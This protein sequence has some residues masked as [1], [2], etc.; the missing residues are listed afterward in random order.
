ME[1]NKDQKAVEAE[2]IKENTSST[3]NSNKVV[4]FIKAKKMIIGVLIIAIILIIVIVNLIVVS[5]KEAV[6]KFVKAF[7]D[8][9]LEKMVDSMD[10][11]GFYVFSGLDEDEYDDFWSEYKDFKDSSDYEDLMDNMNDTLDDKDA[12]ED[13]EDELKDLDY[14]MKIDKIKDVKKISSHLYRVKVKL[15]LSY[16]DEKDTQTVNCYV[17]KDGAKSYVLDFEN[18]SGSSLLNSMF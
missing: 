13:A 5:P 3:N 8:A 9:D 18:S 6:K 17:M 4:E 16:D 10:I 14:S 12:I 1:E 7:N 11:A 2:V 15:E